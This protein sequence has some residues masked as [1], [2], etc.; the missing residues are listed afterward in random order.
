MDSFDDD[1]PNTLP[2]DDAGP[3]CC[4]CGA[5]GPLFPAMCQEKP[6]TLL[7]SPIGMYH[8]PDCSAMVVA[9]FPHPTVCARCTGAT[10]G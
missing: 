8:C 6:E 5:D 7:G 9:G 3:T 4:R 10:H 2:M 1:F